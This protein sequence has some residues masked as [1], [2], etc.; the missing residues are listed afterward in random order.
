[1]EDKIMKEALFVNL[2]RKAPVI[3]ATC[4]W[5]AVAAVVG[6]GAYAVYKANK[7]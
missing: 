1:M 6:V 7:A 2:A 5:L 4:P 3:L